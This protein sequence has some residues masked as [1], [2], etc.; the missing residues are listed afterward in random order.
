M[1]ENYSKHTYLI[2]TFGQSFAFGQSVRKVLPPLQTKKLGE[3]QKTLV[4]I[5]VFLY[6]FQMYVHKYIENV[7]N[8]VWHSC[9]LY[10]KKKIQKKRSVS[11]SENFCEHIYLVLATGQSFAYGQSVRKVLG[12]VMLEMLHVNFTVKSG[13]TMY[14]TCPLIY[15]LS[16]CETTKLDKSIG[17]PTKL[18]NIGRVRLHDWNVGLSSK[19]CF[20]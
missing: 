16:F 1:C 5:F 6:N 8:F 11:M 20:G 13:I 15:Q 17:D 18:S 4:F 14:V 2:S 12:K 19:W 3:Q 9:S 7:S 10:L